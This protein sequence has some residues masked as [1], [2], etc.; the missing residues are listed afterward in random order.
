[1]PQERSYIAID[2]KSFYASVEC[3]DRGLDPLT[4]NLVVAD[5]SRTE[6]TIC[7]AVS[8]S[9][10]SFGIPGRARLFE[11]IQK[12][13]EVNAR[14][15]LDSPSGRLSGKSWKYPELEAD[16]SLAVD[17][18]VAAPRMAR[19]ME[20]STRIYQTYLQYV[21]AEDVH[22]YSIDEVF[23]DATDYLRTYGLSAEQFARKLILEVLSR[24]GITATAGVGPNMYLAK[25]AMDV[26]AK[27]IPA[28][29]NG[30]RIA[31]L[32]EMSYRRKLWDHRPLTDFWRIGRGYARKLEAHGMYTMGDVARCSLGGPGDF[33]N[34]D[35]L[36]SLFG[37]NA[38][39]L[40]DHA[41]GW[42]P[43][44]IADIKAYKPESNSISSGQ[45][46]QDPYGFD[47]AKLVVREMT[48]ALVLELV[49]KGLVSDQMVLDIGYDTLNLT[50]PARAAKYKGPVSVD[51]YGRRMPKMAH[52][53]INLGKY[54][55]STKLITEKTMELFDRIVDPSLLVRRMYVIASHVIAEEDIP[56]EEIEEQLDIFS[57][58]AA[59]DQQKQKEEA[60]KADTEAERRQ[61]QT[62]LEIRKR[63]GK[64]A[65]V[66]GMDLQE[67]ATAI[68]RNGTIGGHR[69]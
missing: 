6:K 65:I 66:M 45:V 26:E 54:T 61:Q 55:S 56:A 4:T 22:V 47:L 23:I 59:A 60:Q 38:E 40:I 69:K 15:A 49:D 28:D 5:L 44:T 25:I 8:P 24:T 12:L 3:S 62:I 21:S 39:L 18:L 31:V 52:G 29:E 67:G 36:Y 37:I 43:C 41:W 53:S 50:D 16:P 58:Q 32:D 1:M 14:R 34:E 10:K 51:A 27:H 42:E 2:L 63:F 13:R 9:L 64:N 17:Y 33:L 48:D 68:Q 35:L 46:L 19:Y 30:V 20:V 7:L 57:L 11:V